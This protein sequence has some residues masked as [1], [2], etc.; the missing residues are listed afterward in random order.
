MNTD[1]R[2]AELNRQSEDRF[3][4]EIRGYIG[5]GVRREVCGLAKRFAGIVSSLDS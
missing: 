2:A 4:K 5:L 3:S 1:D